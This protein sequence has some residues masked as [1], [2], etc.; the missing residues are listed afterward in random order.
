MLLCVP[1]LLP[2]KIEAY[3]ASLAPRRGAVL[4]GMEARARRE[5]IPIV[6]PLVGTLLFQLV[7][8][9]RARRVFECG[10]AIGYSTA[11][12][13]RAVGPRG[14]VFY[15]EADPGRLREARGYLRR[16]GLLS[17]VT[18][19]EGDALRSLRRIPGTFD[20]VFN[21]VDK[22]AYPAV[23]SEASGRIRPGGLFLCD[24][25]LWGG[26]VA[27][28]RS[29]DAWTRAIRRMNRAVARDPRYVSCLLPLRDGVTAAWRRR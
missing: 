8:M 20:A 23:W 16:A 11:W 12:L 25:T 26:S 15:T 28:A 19:L 17:R 21:D 14:R 24:N 5:R 1:P 22:G 7:S 3:L 13:A 9:I 10:S 18:M 2:V 29:R 6:G 4:L 27:E